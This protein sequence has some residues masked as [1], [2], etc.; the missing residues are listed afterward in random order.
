MSKIEVNQIDVQCG[1]TLTVG[2]SGKTVSLATGASQSGF[3]RTGTVDW[4]TTAKTTP[5]TTTIV[6]GKQFYQMIQL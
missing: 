5:F 2:S 3:G 1:S 6:T 4:C